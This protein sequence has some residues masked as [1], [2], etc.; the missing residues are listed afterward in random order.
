VLRACRRLLRP[1]GRTA[2]FTIHIPP[3][4]SRAERRHAVMAGPPGVSTRH[5]HR[6]L[7]ATAGFGNI[8]ETDVT[9]DFAST[10]HGWLEY[11]SGREA[12]LRRAMGD[13]LF[14]ARRSDRRIQSAAVDAGVLRR[15]LFI[16][17]KPVR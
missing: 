4:L 16:A 12:E 5:D 15:S 3:G 11:A 17:D 7:L 1:G 6:T 8:E 10:L 9:A 2:F 13:E 14:D